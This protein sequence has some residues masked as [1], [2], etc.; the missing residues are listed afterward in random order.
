MEFP[1]VEF[2]GGS[3]GPVR[4]PCLPLT[5]SYGARS[6][7]VGHALVDTGADT[8]ILPMA[9]ADLL[10]V[11]FDRRRRA[12]FDSA[13]GGEFV[14]YPSKKKV[15]Y[16]VEQS[17]Y[18]PLVWQGTAFFSDSQPIILLGHYECLELLRLHFDGPC[19]QLRVS[20]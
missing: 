11:E 18:R 19:Q 20:L 10:E 12:V 15:G 14:V 4:R 2:E 3:F 6:F 13:G 8:T 7:P 1:Y 9:I 16:A 5:L 17:G